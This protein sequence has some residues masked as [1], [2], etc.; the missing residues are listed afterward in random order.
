[1]YLV[2]TTPDLRTDVTG[3]FKSHNLDRAGFS[4]E[5]PKSELKA[6]N[7]QVGIYIEDARSGSKDVAFTVQVVKNLNIVPESVAR[8]PAESAGLAYNVEKIQLDPGQVSIS[9][10]AFPEGQDMRGRQIAIVLK[11]DRAVYKLPAA[12]FM[13]PDLAA[14]FKKDLEQAGS[15]LQFPDDVLPPAVYQIGILITNGQNGEQAFRM[16]DK[17]VRISR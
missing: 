13:R 14:Y 11:S 4:A 12:P 1:M 6:G 9:G 8:L 7:Y 17:T 16:T 5:F 10:W 15:D 3:H 2:K